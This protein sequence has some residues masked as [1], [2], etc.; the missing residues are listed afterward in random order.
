MNSLIAY[1]LC[2]YFTKPDDFHRWYLFQSMVRSRLINWSASFMPQDDHMRL[3]YFTR[4]DLVII[5]L[6]NVEKREYK[7][8]YR[9]F[10]Y[11]IFLFGIMFV[12]ALAPAKYLYFPLCKMFNSF[13]F[14]R[15]RSMEDEV[16]S[17]GLLLCT[18]AI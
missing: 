18:C 13:I 17:N 12:T 8:N 5:Y 2:L 6:L 14:Y 9:Y 3:I 15:S 1:A 10:K 7:S 16:I 11:C 4:W